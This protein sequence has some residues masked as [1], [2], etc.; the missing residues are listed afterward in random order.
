VLRDTTLMWYQGPSTFDNSNEQHIHSD[1]QQQ[2][3]KAAH[4]VKT[5]YAE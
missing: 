5:D 2:N 1:D 4:T 3:D